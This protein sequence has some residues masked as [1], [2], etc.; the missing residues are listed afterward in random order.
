MT[1]IPPSTPESRQLTRFFIGFAIVEGAVLAA[2]LLAMVFEVITA[3]QM[4]PLIIGV[5]LVGGLVLTW[6]ILSYTKQRQGALGPRADLPH[7]GPGEPSSAAGLDALGEKDPM[8]K[9]RD[10]NR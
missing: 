9:F 6:R 1:Q 2:I 3:Q 7:E 8:A 4:I 10:P 5:A